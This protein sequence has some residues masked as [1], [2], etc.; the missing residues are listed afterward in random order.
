MFS[1][2]YSREAREA[3]YRQ[4]LGPLMH[5]NGEGGGGGGG[6]KPDDD[7]DEDDEDDKGPKGKA[8][9][10]AQARAIIEKA[11]D[12]EDAVTMLLREARDKRKEMRLLKEKLPADGSVILTGEEAALITTL[13]GPSKLK[14]ALK[15]R[16]DLKTFK[17][18]R[19][20]L[21]I[22]DEAAEVLG[23]NKKVFHD[24]AQ[25]R[26]LTV[27]VATEDV[28]EKDATGKETKVPRKVARVKV[29]SGAPEAL[30]SYVKREMSD[31]LPALETKKKEDKSDFTPFPKQPGKDDGK[32]GDAIQK[33]IDRQAA[34]RKTIHNPLMPKQA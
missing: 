19:E 1:W 26:G 25:A 5:T 23:Y 3:L 24:V 15:E 34:E 29:G 33:E 18:N 2:R 32:P 21:D 12:A 22:H 28:V 30:D 4:G 13:G 6:N 31:Y 10:R 14:D 20:L 27:T 11:R 9:F 8:G 7:D 16:D 17:T